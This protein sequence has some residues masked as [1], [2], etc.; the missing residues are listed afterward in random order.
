MHTHKLWTLALAL[1]MVVFYTQH[2]HTASQLQILLEWW[3]L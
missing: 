1:G 2:K 3:W